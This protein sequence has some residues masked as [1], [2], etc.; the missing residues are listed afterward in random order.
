M[1]ERGLELAHT[2]IMR[3]VQRYVPEF[4]KSWARS[5]P[6]FRARRRNQRTAV[7]GSK[8]YSYTPPQ[9]VANRPENN[10][11]TV[12][13]LAYS[14]QR[15]AILIVCQSAVAKYPQDCLLFASRFSALTAMASQARAA[16]QELHNTSPADCRDC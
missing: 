15:G 6:E 11:K 14:I 7:R 5:W 4:E 8:H 10:K 9:G 2:A 3:W 1:A 13:E 16:P 12:N